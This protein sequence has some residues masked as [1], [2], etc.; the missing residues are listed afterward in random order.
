MVS[1][2]LVPVVQ[3]SKWISR[4]CEVDESRGGYPNEDLNLG[5]LASE[6]NFVPVFEASMVD[7]DE[8]RK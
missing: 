2:E 8:A 1:G 6:A 4:I 3:G 7:D 5:L